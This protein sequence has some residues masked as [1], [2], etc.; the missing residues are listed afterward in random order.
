[1]QTMHYVEI[2]VGDGSYHGSEALTYGSD[3]PLIDGQIVSVS[4]RKKQV[5]GIVKGT[6]KKPPFPVKLIDKVVPLPP[7]PREL[8]T[9]H[10]W[11]KSYYPAPLG[12]ITQLFLPKALAKKP[13]GVITPETRSDAQLPELTSDQIDTLK[14]ID[15][16]GLY[17]L[18]GETGTGKT[19]VYI[20]LVRRALQN[21]KSAII[22]TPEIGLTSQLEKNFREVFGNI[23]ILVHS[24][25][26]D[27]K[28]AAI[29]QQVLSQT[30]PLIVIGARSALFSPIKDLGLIVIDES[31]ETAYKQDQAPRYHA[32]MVAAKLAQLHKATIVLGS[33]TPS[34]TDYSLAKAKG[35]PIL[36]MTH[37]AT[38]GKTPDDNTEIVDLKNKSNFSK[39]PYLSNQLLKAIGLALEKSEQILLFLNRR[40]TARI[41]FCERCGWE[42]LCGNCDLPLVYHGDLH[43]MRCHS[44]GYNAPCPNSCPQCHEVSVVFRSIGTKA[45]VDEVTRL[46]PGARI[47]RFDN[48]NK[49]SERIETHYESLHAGGIDI[50]IGTQTLAKGLDLP[51]LS[52][53]GVVIADT[54]LY[55]PDF[56]A[57]ERTYQLL[58]QVLGRVGRG[59]RESKA[60]IQTYSPDSLLIK[61]AITKD[62][63][64]FYKT[65]L[66]ERQKYIFPPYCY[67]L[68]LTCQRATSA[69]AQRAAEAFAKELE[70]SINGIS[71]EGPTPSF[72]EKSQ[73]K[74]TWQ[75]TIKAK[76]REHLTDIVSILPA[77][78]SYDIDPM[79]LL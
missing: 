25:I 67:L 35:R 76:R 40:G 42:A 63:G 77:N 70:S 6:V 14:K 72:H 10:D 17:L 74:F 4:I 71:I 9:L 33:A 45:L 75:I 58:R 29:W 66:A 12:V 21:G 30:T 46:F 27:T 20:E 5:L 39:S 24:G 32:T 62:W 79:N 50:L 2:L 68:K 41:V 60:I 64:S 57:Q 11:I 47:G 26:T 19:R 38:G 1:M 37:T 18:H 43:I 65:E 56:S 48:D 55:F 16:S 28:R 23:V 52:L 54:S 8:T 53:V 69:G 49:K 7:I 73:N 13:V 51:R 61:S 78:W 15:S 44:C 59:H 36:R 31:H 34:I 3:M 22:L